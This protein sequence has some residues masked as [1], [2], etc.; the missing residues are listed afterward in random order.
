MTSLPQTRHSLL[1]KLQEHNGEAWREF[2]EI[3]ED[4][5]FRFARHRGLQEADARDVTQD[6]LSAVDKRI[7]SWSFDPSKGKFRGWLFRV[8]RNM[9]VDKI[10]RQSKTAGSGDTVVGQFLANQPDSEAGDSTV[11]WFEQRRRLLHWAARQVKPEVKESS[12]T[13]FWL[14]AIEGEKAESVAEKLG[15]QVGSVYAAKFRI[16][17]KLRKVLA[18]IDESEDWS[19]EIPGEGL[20]FKE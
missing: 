2:L 15:V 20:E 5:I 4:A 17:A 19:A 13:A 12:W 3:Y 14:T 11:F 10:V 6:V 7:G 9:A 8:A 1:I 16:V 18:D